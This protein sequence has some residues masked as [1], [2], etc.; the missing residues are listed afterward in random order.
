ML[1]ESGGFLLVES[2][3][4][5]LEEGGGLLLEIDGGFVSV[6]EV[7]VIEDGASVTS[8]NNSLV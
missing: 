1:E 8:G 7:S 2:G 3:G 6:W 4:F 5:L